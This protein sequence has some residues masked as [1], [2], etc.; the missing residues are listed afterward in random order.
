MRST[1]GRCRSIPL[2]VALH[3]ALYL[4]MDLPDL[5]LALRHDV[6]VQHRLENVRAGEP[7]F[8]VWALHRIVPR[9]QIVEVGPTE[10][11]ALVDSGLCPVA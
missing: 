8:I 5:K 10:N 1:S 2:G 6:I 3:V 9:E 4:A 11:V 7:Q